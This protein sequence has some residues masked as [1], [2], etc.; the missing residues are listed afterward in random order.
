V[1][2]IPGTGVG[3]GWTATVFDK[4]YPL[5]YFRGYKTDGIFQNQGQIDQYL[6]QTSISPKPKP[7]DPIVVDT[8]G[9][10]QITSSDQT[11]IGSPHP[12]L[13]FGTRLNMS[14]KGLDL[15]VFVQGSVGNDVL[16]GFSRTDRPTANRPAFFYED[17]WTGEGSTNTWFAANT[18][19]PYVYNSD[20]MVFDGSFARVRQLQLGYTLPNTLMSK[21]RVKNA[22]VYVSLDDYFTFTNYPGMDP[23][24]GNGNSNSLGIDRGGY[25]IPRKAL[26]GLSFNF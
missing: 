1:N 10:K 23:E 22:R 2:E 11:M 15:L 24:A 16:M 9:D 8:N 7:G 5:W 21:I 19:S 3:T 6:T 14:Y 20:L 4:D 18:S 13:L 26:A 25:P 12:D 17:R